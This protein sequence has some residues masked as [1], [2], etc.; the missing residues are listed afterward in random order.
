ML[1]DRRLDHTYIAQSGLAGPGW[2]STRDP[3]GPATTPRLKSY[4]IEGQP[5]D[6]VLWHEEDGIYVEK[7]FR[8]DPATY[9]VELEYEIDNRTAQPMTVN[10]FAQLKRDAMRPE[11]GQGF[12][13]GPRT[14]PGRR[15]HN[16]R[17]RV[18]KKWTSK[19]SRTTSCS[20]R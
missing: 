5:E 13:L 2:A 11:A 9:Y 20:R 12:T 4:R 19:I 17:F 15:A 16:G 8:F 7:R 14:L 10:L 1:L 18:T 6:V 3:A